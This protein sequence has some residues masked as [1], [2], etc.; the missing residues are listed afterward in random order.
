MGGNFTSYNGTPAVNR[1]VRLNVDGTV[2]GAFATGTGF[3]ADVLSLAP[4]GSGNLYV[5]GIF[6]SYKGVAGVNRVVR[7]TAT[8]T[9][10]GTFAT[11]T[12]FNDA[13][14]QPRTRWER[15][16]VCGRCLLQLQRDAGVSRGPAQCG[17]GRWM[18][19]FATGAGFNGGDVLSLA[20]TMGAGT[21]MWEVPSPATNGGGGESRGP[22]HCGRGR[23][24]GP[25]RPEPGSTVT[26]SASHREM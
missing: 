25:L 19:T 8:G 11:G 1:V 12:G 20:P 7:L 15:G 5:G 9:V 6:T 22:A 24:M 2:D 10:D 23:W 3:N 13:R 18:R 14:V 21:C 16:P 26:C 4:D 17:R